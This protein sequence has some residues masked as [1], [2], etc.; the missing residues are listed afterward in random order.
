MKRFTKGLRRMRTWMMMTVLSLFTLRDT[1]SRMLAWRGWLRS[2]G[3]HLESSQLPSTTSSSTR[4]QFVPRCQK[5]SADH[6]GAD[7]EL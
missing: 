5:D 1:S 7:N 3:Y 2:V 6:Q 4:T